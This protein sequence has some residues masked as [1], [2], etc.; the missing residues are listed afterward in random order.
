MPNVFVTLDGAIVVARADDARAVRATVPDVSRDV[1]LRTIV[2]FDV[3]RADE[4]FWRIVAP[5]AVRATVAERDWPELSVLLDVRELVLDVVG[6]VIVFCAV[7]RAVVPRMASVPFDAWFGVRVVRAIT[8]VVWSVFCVCG[9]TTVFASR[10]AASTFA[11]P[12]KHA[13]TKGTIFFIILLYND[14]KNLFLL[15]VIFVVN[16][17]FIKQN[18]QLRRLFLCVCRLVR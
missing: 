5:V 10:T 18:R 9:R 11:M 17:E 8:A 13:I 16:A 4:L 7:L 6:R 3:L 1:E 2:L 14:S 12:N 15:K